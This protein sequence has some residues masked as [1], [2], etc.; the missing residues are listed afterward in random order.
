MSYYHYPNGNFP[1]I[2]LPRGP[3]KPVSTTNP[4]FD[5]A[6]ADREEEMKQN[7]TKWNKTPP[8]LRWIPPKFVLSS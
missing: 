4:V 3:M 7:E 1:L 8:P 2:L 6:N 5:P